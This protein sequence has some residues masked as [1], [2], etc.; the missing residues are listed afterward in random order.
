MNT[1]IED[2]TIKHI[3]SKCLLVYI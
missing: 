1:C 2:C 3:I